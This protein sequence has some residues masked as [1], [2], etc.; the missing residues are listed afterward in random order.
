MKGIMDESMLTLVSLT[1]T[2]LQGQELTEEEEEMEVSDQ[3]DA[4]KQYIV[5]KLI[6]Q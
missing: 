1:D 4:E 3:E 6:S 5:E 2:T